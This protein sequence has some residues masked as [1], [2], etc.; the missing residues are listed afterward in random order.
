MTDLQARAMKLIMLSIAQVYEYLACAQKRA[1]PKKIRIRA[2]DV[3]LTN[4]PVP[5]LSSES[6]AVSK[7]HSAWMHPAQS[8]APHADR[9]RR[10]A[11]AEGSASRDSRW[12]QR[13]DEARRLA[14]LT[15]PAGE[16]AMQEVVTSYQG[17]P[18]QNG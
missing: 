12:R 17:K 10:P 9:S 16:Q 8:T 4:E 13:A 5:R 3:T 2:S 18:L 6:S 11:A 14:E 15:D 1:D 7:C